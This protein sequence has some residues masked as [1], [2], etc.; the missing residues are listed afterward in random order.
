MLT[1]SLRTSLTG[2]DPTGGLPPKATGWIV[3][4]T[5]EAPRPA[6]ATVTWPIRRA[7]VPKALVSSSRI[8]SPPT[9]GKTM[10]RTV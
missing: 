9:L 5:A 3:P 7:E 10:S 6:S 1:G 2:R 4:G 8:R